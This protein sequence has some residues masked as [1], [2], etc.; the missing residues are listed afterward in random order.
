MNNTVHETII[1][2]SHVIH[3]QH[4]TNGKKILSTTKTKALAGG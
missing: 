4:D 2:T 3:E 1:N